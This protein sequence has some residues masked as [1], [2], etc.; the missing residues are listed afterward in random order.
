MHFIALDNV[1]DP[2]GAV[3]DDQIDWLKAE[4]GKVDKDAP[5]VVLTHR[6]LFDLYPQWDWATADGAKVTRCSSPTGTSRC[7][8]G[9]STR[10]TTG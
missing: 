7:S 1:S 8:T 3:G 4:L 6:P 10:R 2:S 5:I 9:T